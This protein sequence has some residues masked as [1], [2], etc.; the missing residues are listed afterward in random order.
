MLLEKG[1][2]AGR[3]HAALERDGLAPPR[4]GA[5]PRGVPGRGRGPAAAAVAS[6][7]TT[8]SRWLES[9]GAPVTERDTGNPLTT[10][11]RFDPGGLRDALLEA[12]GGARLEEPLTELPDRHAARARHR[13]LPGRPRA[14]AR[15]RDLP[16]R[17]HLLLRAAP[18]SS[19]DG[20]TAGAWRRRA[21]LGGDGRVL[22]R[23]TCPRRRRASTPDQ[24]V[25]AGPALRAPRARARRER[26]EL[27]VPDVVR[28]R[29]GRSGRR[30]ARAPGPGTRCP[31]EALDETRAR[32]QRRRRWWPPPS[33]RARRWSAAPVA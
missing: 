1:D 4:L 18:W 15:A 29:R 8:E 23:A 20:L 13:R 22:R 24:F 30:A 12:A 10:G 31:T 27:R 9:L 28:D 17:D 25:A 33:G 6:G 14:R 26:R 5:L 19:G 16:R 3:E 21:P 2:R 32:P 11:V 7:S